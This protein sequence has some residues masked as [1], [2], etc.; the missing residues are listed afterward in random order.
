MELFCS[1]KPPFPHTNKTRI[2]WES[3][4]I[5]MITILCYGA[6]AG[7]LGTAIGCII[8]RFLL[9]IGKKSKTLH[10]ITDK[11]TFYSILF[12]FSS[13]LMMAIV[14]FHLLPEAMDTGGV[15]Y[16]FLGLLIGL[17]LLFFAG[18]Y[19]H[20]RTK[21]TS[22]GFFLFLGILIHNIPEGI[23]IGTALVN[24]FSLAVS[25]LT[26]IT[27]HDIPEGI[28]AF[29]SY[30][31]GER[32][33]PPVVLMVLLCGVCTALAALVG[34]LTG[35]ISPGLNAVSLGFA[36]GAMLY[37]LTFELSREAGRLSNRNICDVAYILGLVLGI[38]LK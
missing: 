27:V 33:K 7:T 14:T 22:A 6:L 31:A 20:R 23:A 9:S 3:M 4:A 8:G 32:G 10:Q 37:I 35:G 12:E 24:H 36:A 30:G 34:N 18:K 26:V 2:K 16:A 21:Q 29:L 1:G 38:L 11:N 19:L 13:G 17:F 25:L 28:S 5:F 15:F